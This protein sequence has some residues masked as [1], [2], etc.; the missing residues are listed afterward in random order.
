[1]ILDNLTML[2]GSM[3]AAGVLTGQAVNGAG[4]ILST[5]T[6]DLSPNSLGGNQLGDVGGGESMEFEITVMTAP[7][8]GTSVQ[9]QLIQAD[10]AALT[11]NVQVINQTDAFLL[12][13]LPVGTLIPLHYDRA[14]PYLPKRYLGIRYVN[15][16][17]VATASYMAG[18]VKDMA[19]TKN[20]TYTAGWSVT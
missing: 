1:M 11:T 3:S 6:M 14:M 12:F 18:M 5:N 9:F 19:T 2:S 10:D 13:N 20:M 8:V 15:V 7:T 17:A 4:S 16:G